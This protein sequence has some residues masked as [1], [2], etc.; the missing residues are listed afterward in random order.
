MALNL[1]DLTEEQKKEL[2]KQ[3]KEEEREKKQ[4]RNEELKSLNEMTNETVEEI[5]VVAKEVVE[6]LTTFKKETFEKCK[7]LIGIKEELFNVKDNQ[8]SHTFTTDDG[9]S[10]TL[11]YRVT[12]AFDD[13]VK[14]GI[15]KVKNWVFSEVK[16]TNNENIKKI[17]SNML[18]EDKKGNLN[19]K[20]VLELSQIAMDI[21]D[22]ELTEAVE[23]IE[24]AYK[25]QK[26]C[27]FI[28]LSYKDEN[29]KKVSMPLSV[30]AAPFEN[31]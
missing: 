24:K 29:G 4:K 14:V 5:F 1:N 10:V 6:I 7:S 25:P 15:E 17:I 20:R 22:D 2:L 16:G 3:M 12:D 30:S 13:T 28:E 21:N 23:I 27:Y 9:K 26:S 18:K 11:G 19:A 8:R 31:S